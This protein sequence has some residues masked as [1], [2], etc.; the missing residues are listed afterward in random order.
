ML[1]F[2]SLL[3]ILLS[4]DIFL[5]FQFFYSITTSFEFQLNYLFL[6]LV[7]QHRVLFFTT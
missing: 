3:S 4:P 2:V 7:A 1:N 5:S 6:V